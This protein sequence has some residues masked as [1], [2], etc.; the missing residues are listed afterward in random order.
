MKLKL[1][2]LWLVV[3][4]FLIMNIISL[5]LEN[6]ALKKENGELKQD[7]I[8]YKWQL[9]QVPMIMESVKDEWCKD[10]K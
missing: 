2:I 7:I 3:A 6:E 8:D 4:V 10:Y 9:E 1:A 5:Q